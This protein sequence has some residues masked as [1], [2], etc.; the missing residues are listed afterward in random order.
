[1]RFDC[2]RVTFDFVGSALSGTSTSP[3]TPAP[4]T[5]AL[6]PEAARV[7][8]LLYNNGGY[9][10]LSIVAEVAGAIPRERLPSIA[11]GETRRQ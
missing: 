3:R 6:I 10:M 9:V 11:A 5:P 7:A 4:S 2:D 1:M 8:E